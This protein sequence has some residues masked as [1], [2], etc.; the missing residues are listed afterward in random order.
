VVLTPT[1]H[2]E[3]SCSN[4]LLG[5][6]L[7]GDVAMRLAGAAP[8]GGRVGGARC[9]RCTP[10]PSPRI[11][12]VAVPCLALA[13]ALVSIA[14]LGGCKACHGGSAPAPTDA[15]GNAAPQDDPDRHL[16]RST[17][18][19]LASD[20]GDEEPLRVP[21]RVIGSMSRVE[22]SWT[23]G[24]KDPS[25]RPRGVCE[26]LLD[27][28]TVD[29]P[30]AHGVTWVSAAVLDDA[31]ALVTEP[32][33]GGCKAQLRRHSSAPKL[34]VLEV[35]EPGCDTK[36]LTGKKL[37]KGLRATAKGRVRPGGSTQLLD[38]MFELAPK[39]K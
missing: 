3:V 28:V 29:P 37:P 2:G 20:A 12:L 22:C 36:S 7:A 11:A 23:P 10:V 18:G 19:D 21:V 26:I 4:G 15:G 27:E 1:P 30:L 32:E 6:H 14:A 38:M 16:E 13:L 24:S 33:I 17:N 31:Q 8:G 34:L 5:E 25:G 35:S 39:A 9:V